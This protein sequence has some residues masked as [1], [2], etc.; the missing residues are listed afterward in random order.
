M[1]KY[2]SKFE[3]D[4]AAYQAKCGM[5]EFNSILDFLWYCYSASSPIDDGAIRE[6][7]GKLESV[8]QE[9]SVVSADALFD[10]I[11]NLCT[12]YQR[13]AYLEGL[14]TGY[15]LTVELNKT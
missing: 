10:L 4:L 7:E 5:E 8:F 2:I 14:L 15:Q 9:L 1:N 3:Q 13:A 6:H 12:A 11:S